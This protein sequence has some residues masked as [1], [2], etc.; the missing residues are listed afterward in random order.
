MAWWLVL[1]AIIDGVGKFL[2]FIR[3]AF[4]FVWNAVMQFMGWIIFS[5]P[6]FFKLIFF[7]I[8]FFFVGGFVINNTLGATHVCDSQGRLM[9]AG[10]VSA[11]EYK[12]KDAFYTDSVNPLEEKQQVW[13][14]IPGQGNFSECSWQDT[15]YDNGLPIF[16][17]STLQIGY[18]YNNVYYNLT[19]KRANETHW[20]YEPSCA[21]ERDGLSGNDIN[22]LGALSGTK[23]CEYTNITMP[24]GGK[25]VYFDCTVLSTDYCQVID[26]VELRKSNDFSGY[27]LK[28]ENYNFAPSS[29]KCIGYVYHDPDCRQKCN[30]PEGSYYDPADN[31]YK[32][33]STGKSLDL[34]AV[35]SA[36]YVTEDSEKSNYFK[37]TE[38]TTSPIGFR[39]DRDKSGLFLDN[40]TFVVEGIP[41]F[42]IR[43]AGAIIAATLIF[44]LLSLLRK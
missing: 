21:F 15:T 14:L 33:I 36:A 31:K 7:M 25:R 26:V 5:A 6:G 18:L 19:A 37:Y 42:D 32:T 4:L 22:S 41:V 39:C 11:M 8:L 13:G 10:F 1:T 2:G 17:S 43:F 38:G 40:A 9:E 23:S 24:N 20:F 12:V 3:D 29:K 30:P 44:W 28:Q 16:G 34:G 35:A 27:F